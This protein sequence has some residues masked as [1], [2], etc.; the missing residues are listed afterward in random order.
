MSWWSPLDELFILKYHIPLEGLSSVKGMI[1]GGKPYVLVNGIVEYEHSWVTSN[2]SKLYMLGVD[3]VT[4]SVTEFRQV[5]N[6]SS[7][8]QV[9]DAEHFRH[10]YRD[11]LLILNSEHL[12]LHLWNSMTGKFEVFDSVAFSGDGFEVICCSGRRVAN[13]CSR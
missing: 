8:L 9:L 13:D 12:I 1:L 10:D 2:Y 7:S 6:L 5:Q 3:N 4:Q 11:Y